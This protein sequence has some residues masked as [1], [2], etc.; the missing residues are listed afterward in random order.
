MII[1]K[2]NRN[3]AKSP[4]KVLFWCG[5]DRELVSGDAKCPVCGVRRNKKRKFKKVIDIELDI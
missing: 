3:E 4:R 5:C 1:R 2:H